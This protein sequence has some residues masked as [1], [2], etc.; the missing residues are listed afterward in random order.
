MASKRSLGPAP[1]QAQLDAREEQFLRE[2]QA[3]A[4]RYPELE[5]RFAITTASRTAGPRGRSS[6]KRRVCL[7][8]GKDPVNN[9][10][11]CIRWSS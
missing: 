2:V 3:L 9:R 7:A 6:T 4:E 8:W 10:R 1:S 11:I 5:G